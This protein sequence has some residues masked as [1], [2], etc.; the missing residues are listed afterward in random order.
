VPRHERHVDEQRLRLRANR[1]PRPA[2]RGAAGRDLGP[3]AG[4]GRRR[5][6]G[7]RPGCDRAVDGEGEG[8]AQGRHPRR[9]APA[10]PRAP[11]GVQPGSAGLF[12]QL[13]PTTISTSDIVRSVRPGS[14]LTTSAFY[15][16]LSLSIQDRHGYEILKDVTLSSAGRV[17]MGPGIVY[18]T[19]KRLLE[20]GLIVEVEG[21][22]DADRDEDRKSVVQ[23]KGVGWGGEGG[24]E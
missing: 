9:R 13:T 4:R 1:R 10:E 8:R 15:I 3:D 11:R 19:L 22:A 6:R 7:A 21:R 5:G 18:T 20:V 23:G 12:A 24:V 2:G 16:L 14:S 17:Q